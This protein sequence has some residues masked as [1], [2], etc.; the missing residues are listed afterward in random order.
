[1]SQLHLEDLPEDVYRRLQQRAVVQGSTLA[2]AAQ[3]ML[4]DAVRAKATLAPAALRQWVTDLY[5]GSPPSDVVRDLLAERRAEAAS[6]VQVGLGS[7]G[8]PS[9]LGDGGR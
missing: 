6:G 5:G 2:E 4:T 9:P 1:M 3:A 8:V 7:V